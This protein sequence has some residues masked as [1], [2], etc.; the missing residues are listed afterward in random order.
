MLAALTHYQ[1]VVL[2]HGSLAPEIWGRVVYAIH[3]QPKN[4]PCFVDFPGF[5]QKG[6]GFVARLYG[7]PEHLSEVVQRIQPL[8]QH[9][10]IGIQDTLPVPPLDDAAEWGLTLRDKATHTARERRHQKRAIERAL[11]AGETLPE[12]SAP[13]P[14]PLEQCAHP[15]SYIKMMSASTQ[16]QFPLLIR[17]K[18]V[19]S[20]EAKALLANPRG[21]GSYGLGTPVPLIRP[22]DR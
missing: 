15:R 3:L 1:D 16:T 10:F 5:C 6:M 22:I 18:V 19:S 7:T 17:R 20:E 4:R 2:R 13:K 12:F 21:A 14:M 8:A 9:N 11:K